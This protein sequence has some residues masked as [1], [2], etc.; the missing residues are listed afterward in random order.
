MVPNHLRPFIPINFGWG[1]FEG[2]R[3][4]HHSNELTLLSGSQVNFDATY[5]VTLNV[6]GVMTQVLLICVISY[7]KMRDLLNWEDGLEAS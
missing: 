5:D 7:A 1:L 2:G 6:M 4:G 3:P